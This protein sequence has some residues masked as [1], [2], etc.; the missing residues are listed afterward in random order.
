MF[1]KAI[2]GGGW[3][4]ANPIERGHAGR[5]RAAREKR[6]LTEGQ[7]RWLLGAPEGAE[8]PHAGYL[9]YSVCRALMGSKSPKS[10]KKSL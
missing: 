6:K 3:K 8:E 1:T 4:D 5:K 7:T 9:T 10:K 2:E